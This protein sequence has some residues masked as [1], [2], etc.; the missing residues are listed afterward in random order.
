MQVKYPFK[1]IALHNLTRDPFQV[2]SPNGPAGR[3]SAYWVGFLLNTT[4]VYRF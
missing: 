2:P 3:F 4:Q 1:V